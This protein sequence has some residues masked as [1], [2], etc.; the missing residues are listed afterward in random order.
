MIGRRG[1]ISGAL[2]LVAAAL[3]PWRVPA[4]EPDEKELMGTP[5]IDNM[6]FY[7]VP[8][9][10]R[11]A[12]RTSYLPKAEWRKLNEG[13]VNGPHSM[14]VQVAPGKTVRFGLP[15]SSLT[16]LK[17]EWAERERMTATEVREAQ[18]RMGKRLHD[19]AVQDFLNAG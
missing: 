17:R 10:H 11:V 8:K 19:A 7:E 3:M 18:E 14:T 15:S 12:R 9:G 2:G 1:F 13:R 5:I 6:P 4:A 16:G